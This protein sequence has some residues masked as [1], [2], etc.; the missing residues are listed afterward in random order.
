MKFLSLSLLSVSAISTLVS[1]GPLTATIDQL[2]VFRS[3]EPERRLIQF[4]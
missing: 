1:A 3:E 2:R 4:R